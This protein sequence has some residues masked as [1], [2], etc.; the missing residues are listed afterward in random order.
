[1]YYIYDINYNLGIILC[2]T[3][4]AITIIILSFFG[5][6]FDNYKPIARAWL[7]DIILEQSQYSIAFTTFIGGS[8]Y[9]GLGFG[10]GLGLLIA[11]T[12]VYITYNYY[13]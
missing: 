9:F 13:I 1:M 7:C 5:G 3:T 8:I 11:E 10:I 2:N 12:M 6:I 4:F